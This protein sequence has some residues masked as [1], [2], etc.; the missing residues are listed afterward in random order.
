MYYASAFVKPIP[1]V[2]MLI[3]ASQSLA[4]HPY[5]WDDDGRFFQ[6]NT[7]RSSAWEEN[8]EGRHFRSWGENTGES[9]VVDWLYLELDQTTGGWDTTIARNNAIGKRVDQTSTNRTVGYEYDFTD[10]RT[11]GSG[12]W[13]SGAKVVFFKK[14]QWN[15]GDNLVGSYECYVVEN[16]NL[17]AEQLKNRFGLTHRGSHSVWGRTYQQYTVTMNGI[18]QVWA[19]RSSIPIVPAVS[20]GSNTD[21]R[22]YIPVGQMKKHW[23]E[24]RYVKHN[25]FPLGWM[26]FIETQGRNFGADPN[27]R[28]IGSLWNLWLPLND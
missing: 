24:K 23:R 19:I 25:Y 28:S 18:F 5:S 22:L 4:Q 10:L 26:A 16:S 8:F 11:A 21:L 27:N 3:V 14:R 9:W 6:D 1:F 12:A 17:S 15:T 7:Y 20:Q 2:L 13:W